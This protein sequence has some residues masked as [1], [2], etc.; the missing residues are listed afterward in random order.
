[1]FPIVPHLLRLGIVGYLEA[2]M[3]NIVELEMGASM[4]H[5]GRD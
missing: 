5:E 3:V 1:M 4:E 2:S